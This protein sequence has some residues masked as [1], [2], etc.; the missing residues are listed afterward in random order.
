[1]LLTLSLIL[2]SL[3][4]V[5][6][7]TYSIYTLIPVL[8]FHSAPYIR[9][10]ETSI[11]QILEFAQIKQGI[12]VMDIGSGDGELC[13]RAAKMGAKTLGIEFNPFLVLV[14]RIR[15]RRLG[16]GSRTTFIAKNFWRMR[17]PIETDIVFCYL[18]PDVMKELWPKLV[19]ELKPGTVVISNSFYIPQAKPERE[20]EGVMLYR[21]VVK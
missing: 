1:M 12:H 9:S 20:Q 6:I 21:I 18:R 14:S 7:I 11:A 8:F 17:L 13:L 16:V 2:I 4:V 15:A 5:A 10:R 19:A 3:F